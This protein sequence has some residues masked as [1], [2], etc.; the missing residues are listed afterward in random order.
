MRKQTFAEK[1]TKLR[2]DCVCF[3]GANFENKHNFGKIIKIVCFFK[4][5]TTC[6]FN[7]FREQMSKSWMNL[8]QLFVPYHSNQV[9]PS[10]TV[11]HK[12]RIKCEF[13]Y[14]QK[15]KL[16]LCIFYDF[17]ENNVENIIVFVR[18]TMSFKGKSILKELWKRVC[19]NH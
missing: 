6:F 12:K 18:D 5:T 4:K 15:N 8:N 3:V 19:T 17:I 11:F 7:K 2:R 14:Q 10:R 9:K 1:T 13:L 16:F